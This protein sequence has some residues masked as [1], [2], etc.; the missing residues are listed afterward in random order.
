MPGWAPR[1]VC[2]L[3]AARDTRRRD[4]GLR[5]L[6]ADGGEEPEFADT[7]GQLVV[8]GL[9]TERAGHAAAPSVNL[10]DLRAWDAAQQGHGRGRARQRLLVAVTVE[11]DAAP[12]KVVL[13][14]HAEPAGGDRF[15]EQ[16]LRE[17]GG[18]RHRLRSRITR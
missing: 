15:H 8:L 12:A 16:F 5:R 6:G 2:Y 13:L 10:N 7:H 14:G 3:L 11:H 4:D 17:A 1:P 18:R 9:E